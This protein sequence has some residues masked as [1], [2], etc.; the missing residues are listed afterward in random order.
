MID[1]I[2]ALE[3]MRRLRNNI[4]HAFGREIEAARRHDVLSSTEIS[5]LSR[6][7]TIYYMKLIYSISKEID[8][9]LLINH[10]GE[11][12]IANFYHSLK[13]DLSIGDPLPARERGNH[14]AILKK[15]IGRF[16]NNP[17]SKNFC[18]E[19]IEYYERL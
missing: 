13:D 4:G 16:G 1:N 2:S 6:D 12:Q 10:I 9:Q 5:K 8:R 19:L 17:V 3:K 15:Q 7:T 11:Y 14:I 18:R